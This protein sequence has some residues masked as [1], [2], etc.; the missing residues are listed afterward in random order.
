M[1]IVRVRPSPGGGGR[2]ATGLVVP[3]GDPD[4]LRASRATWV[5][6][7][8]RGREKRACAEVPVRAVPALGGNAPA[9]EADHALVQD[10]GRGVGFVRERV[11]AQP[12]DR[13]ANLR[14]GSA[15]VRDLVVVLNRVRARPR[16]PM[17]AATPGVSAATAA[18]GVP[19]AT[20][21]LA[22]GAVPN[23][24]NLANRAAPPRNA[25]RRARLAQNSPRRNRAGGEPGIP[26]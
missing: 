3:L 17:H 12:R 24:A 16:G 18:K 6:Q 2:R 20:G 8:S 14:A 7:G 22:R 5:A 10:H 25:D 23:R 19:V 11:R 1:T 21:G 13:A 15:K 4:V 26:A 9:P